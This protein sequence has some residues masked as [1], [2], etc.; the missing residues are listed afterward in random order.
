[1]D[2]TLEQAVT[3]PEP[4][5]NAPQF[6]GVPVD[7]AASTAAGVAGEGDIVATEAVA[8]PRA[9]AAAEAVAAEPPKPILLWRPGRFDRQ[10]GNRPEHRRRNGQRPADGSGSESGRQAGDGQHAEGGRPEGSRKVGR[11]REGRQGDSGGAA[12]AGR[13][14]G[15][16]HG[17]PRS[18]EERRDGSQRD[19]SG[20]DNGRM[21]RA[22]R[23]DRFRERADSAQKPAFQSKPR[24][25]RPFEV[26]PLSPFAKLAALRDQLKK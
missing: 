1:V 5:A 3:A 22:D 8:G 7:A 13:Q 10:R 4:A 11:D 20:A 17:R 25:D 23:R 26:D 2:K 12:E 9:A 15:R 18:G 21:D 24:E 19:R 16:H 14:Q 6:D